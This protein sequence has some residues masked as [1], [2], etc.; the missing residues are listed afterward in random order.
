M[1]WLAH[2]VDAVPCRIAFERGKERH[3]C[4]LAISMGTSGWIVL[5]EELPLKPHYGAVRVVAPLAGCKPRID[6]KHPRWLHLRIRPSTI[7]FIDAAHGK[8]KT[9]ALVDGRWT[10]AFRDEESC[11]SAL[12]MILEEANL[13]GNEVERRLKPL[14]DLERNLYCS[15]PETE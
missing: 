1:C 7:P 8:A 9:K 4:F 12:S 14:L 2:S 5:A 11:K 3:F 10:L 15:A 6:D 13:Q